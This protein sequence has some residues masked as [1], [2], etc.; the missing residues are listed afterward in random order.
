MVPR[1]L[2][3]LDKSRLIAHLTSLVGEDRRLR[4]GGVVNDDYIANYIEKSFDN[5]SKWFAIEHIDGHIVAACHVALLGGDA[6]LGCSVD[7]E[8]RGQ[9]YAQLL[10]DRAIT[11]LRARGINHVF[12]HCL[13]ENA[14]MKHI[15]RKNDMTIVSRYGES[16]AEVDIEPATP[17][18]P[19][20]DA[21]MDRIA[22]YD[23]MY[24]NTYRVFKSI[25]G[26]KTP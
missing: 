9:G 10:F 25:M 18:T 6:E 7:K 2:S 13:S 19:I 24:K 15:A 4:F 12:M 20:E 17:M 3:I 26:V 16:D 14:T 11:W 8:Y 5:N 21:Y 1:K 23:M 22:M